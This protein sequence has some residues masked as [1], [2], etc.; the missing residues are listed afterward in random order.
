MGLKE[1]IPVEAR[2]SQSRHS[3]IIHPPNSRCSDVID[4]SNSFQSLSTKNP[5]TTIRSFASVEES[6]VKSEHQSIKYEQKHLPMPGVRVSSR[7]K[8]PNICSI[9]LSSKNSVA[10]TSPPASSTKHENILVSNQH[11][12]DRGTQANKRHHLEEIEVPEDSS[13]PL[14]FYTRLPKKRAKPWSSEQPLRPVK[15]DMSVFSK[16]RRK[17]LKL[18]HS[19]THQREPMSVRPYQPWVLPD[20]EMWDSV[21]PSV[22]EATLPSCVSQSVDNS[23]DVKEESSVDNVQSKDSSKVDVNSFPVNAPHVNN[24]PK[25]K[26]S[27]AKVDGHEEA[28]VNSNNMHNNHQT[29]SQAAPTLIQCQTSNNASTHCSP[30]HKKINSLSESGPGNRTH[31]AQSSVS[32][33]IVV[34]G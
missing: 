30:K 1:I 32:T 18:N 19:F 11:K 4:L 3:E 2:S 29:A 7:P 23:H 14:N 26:S 9:N 28:S 20:S 16:L 27:P 31:N 33:Y 21:A 34:N 13:D 15:R 25:T 8:Q 24:F 22:E 6:K 12:S 5:S 17:E 10:S